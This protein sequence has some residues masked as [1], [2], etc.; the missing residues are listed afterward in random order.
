MQGKAALSVPAVSARSQCPQ[1]VLAVSARSVGLIAS[2]VVES[3][4]SSPLRRQLLVLSA[5]ARRFSCV[6]SPECRLT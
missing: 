1:S 2:F 4:Q 5:I 3:I 6:L